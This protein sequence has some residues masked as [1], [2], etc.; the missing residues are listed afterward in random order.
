[1]VYAASTYTLSRRALSAL[2]F[3]S[4]LDRF[5]AWSRRQLPDLNPKSL[6][7]ISLEASKGAITMGNHT[8]ESLLLA[9]F[10]FASGTYGIV[11]VSLRAPRWTEVLTVSI[12]TFEVRPPQTTT[13][14]KLHKR[15]LELC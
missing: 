7:P 13:S 5:Y 8:T 11:Q 10:T 14:F 6:L 9:Q 15:S 3:P 4:F 2:R 12:V 1:M